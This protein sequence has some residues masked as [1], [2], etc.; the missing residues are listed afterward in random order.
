M[1]PILMQ[2]EVENWLKE[3][4]LNYTTETCAVML[5][6]ISGTQITTNRVTYWL[7]KLNLKKSAYQE[8]TSDQ[9]RFIRDK[10]A[11][12]EWTS[13]EIAIELGIRH[14]DVKQFVKTDGLRKYG[15]NQ[16]PKR[17]EVKRVP[18][19]QQNIKHSDRV[20]F[21]NNLTLTQIK[22]HKG[23]INY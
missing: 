13:Q 19:Q 6:K 3:N 5:S 17:K 1:K 14:Q 8:P 21:W 10:Y 12:L 15:V 18:A 22:N 2:P 16:T 4:Y 20:D 9:K 11:D 7:T 23:R